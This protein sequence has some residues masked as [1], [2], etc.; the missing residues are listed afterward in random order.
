MYEYLL[1]A[2]VDTKY[3]AIKIIIRFEMLYFRKMGW[4][5]EA[6]YNTLQDSVGNMMS[7]GNILVK[8]C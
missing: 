1:H 5:M 7:L 8:Y 4:R 6:F 3:N 2:V